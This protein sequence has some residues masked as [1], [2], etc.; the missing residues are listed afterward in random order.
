MEFIK[1][2]LYLFLSII[3]QSINKYY[4][5]KKEFY[6]IIIDIN[7]KVGIFCNHKW[8]GKNILNIIFLLLIFSLLWLIIEILINV[9]NYFK[10]TSFLYI[11]E[12]PRLIDSP[13]FIQIQKLYYFNNY[14]SID[15]L[16]L[17][18]IITPIL[19]LIK[20]F[21]LEYGFDKDSKY[22]NTFKYIKIFCYLIFIIGIIYYLI[23]YK[24]IT[25]LGI[26]IN[27]ANN[28]IYNNINADFINSEK[29][30]NYLHK[31]TQ[32]DHNFVYGK[33]NDIRNNISINKLYNYIKKITNEIHEN[34]APISNI[35]IDMFKT[36]KDKNGILYKDKIISA[37]FTYQLVKYYIDND[38]I[39]EAKDFFATYNIFYLKN[40]NLLRK[41]I[42]PILY[43]RFDDLIIFNKIFEY[44]KKMANSFGDNKDIYNYIYSEINNIQNI[45]QNIVID[46]YN[47]CSYKLISVYAYYFIIFLILLTFIIIYIYYY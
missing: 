31:K 6:D 20:L 25:A 44:N 32:F 9:Y 19:I 23:I 26:R 15:I 33:C 37:L 4:E 11:K 3:Y 41:K 13:L 5:E 2:K 12:N 42:N 8:I 40:I 1:Q 17:I 29:I 39:E 46:I 34:I 24:H 27:T 38:L 7:D 35:D 28:I 22:L 14:F 30:C 18:F 16:F 21:I 45:I 36:L 43:L 10:L 47:I